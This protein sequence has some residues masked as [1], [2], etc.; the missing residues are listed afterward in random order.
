MKAKRI[1]ALLLAAVLVVSLLP[2]MAL[3]DGEPAQVDGVYQIGTAAEMKWFADA[4]NAEM[5]KEAGLVTMDAVLTADIDL[6]GAEWT[7]IAGATAYVT[8]AYAGTFDGQGHSV[9]GLSVSGGSNLGLFG[10]VNGGTIKNVRVSGTV[11]GSS[12]V[13]GVV[14]KIQ[15]GTVENCSMSGSVTANAKT[16]YAGGI[17]GG[18]NAAG[19]TVSGC[20]NTASVTG[21]NAG[22]ILGQSTK[23][24]TVEYCYNTGAISGTTREGGI[25]GQLSSGAISYCYNVGTSAC[26]IAPGGDARRPVA[27][28]RAL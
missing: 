27:Q 24:G 17:V 5:E 13:G 16:A 9:T 3:A 6:G 10:I 21:T 4:V 25:A 14:G 12:Y 7:P 23:K 20:V 8:Y 28:V 19:A 2:V 1:L 26:G 15:T 11:T 18:F 22:G